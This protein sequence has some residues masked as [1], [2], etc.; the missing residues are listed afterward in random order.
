M[1]NYDDGGN[2]TSSFWIESPIKISFFAW[3]LQG[4]VT[5]FEQCWTVRP[6]I[7]CVE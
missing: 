7:L 4:S 6:G 2:I 5:H 3:N 1:R